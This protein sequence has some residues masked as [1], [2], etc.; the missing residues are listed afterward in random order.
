MENIRDL[1]YS[2]MLSRDWRKTL[3]VGLGVL[4]LVL[5]FTV[6]QPFLYSATTSVLVIQKSG[7]VDVF[8]KHKGEEATANSMANLIGTSAFYEEMIKSGFDIDLSYFPS[9]EQKKREKWLDSFETEVP[10]GLSKLT[11]SVYHPNPNQAMQISQAVIMTL[12]TKQQSYFQDANIELKMIDAP[13]VSKYPVKPDLALNLILG[14][15]LGVVVGIGYTVA[16]YNPD[17]DKLVEIIPA[18]TEGKADLNENNLEEIFEEETDE[19]E[20]ELKE[21]EDSLYPKQ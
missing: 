20:E 8:S 16:T 12:I 13:L 15:L 18:K 14:M 21:I 4:L 5:I 11:V 7:Y 3:I 9:D 2:E 1:K 17:K 19:N 10:Q 6:I